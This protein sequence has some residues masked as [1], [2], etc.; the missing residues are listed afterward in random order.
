MKGWQHMKQAGH[1]NLFR[2]PNQLRMLEMAICRRES[3]LF[4]NLCSR[5]EIA[6]FECV[7]ITDIG[8]HAAKVGFTLMPRAPH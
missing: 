2:L 7:N 1:L 6:V 3:I 8:T 4:L 5:L